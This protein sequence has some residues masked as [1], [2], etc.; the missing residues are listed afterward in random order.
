[1]FFL[2]GECFVQSILPF[3]AFF[4]GLVYFEEKT[5]NFLT[6]SKGNFSLGKIFNFAINRV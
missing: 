1:M 3:H 2:K 4:T 6:K 5:I